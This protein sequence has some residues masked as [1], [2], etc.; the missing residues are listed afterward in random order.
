MWDDHDLRHLALVPEAAHAHGAL[1]GIDLNSIRRRVEASRD[2]LFA[3]TG[4]PLPTIDF[5]D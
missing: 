1:A 4:W 2:F 3:K 5:S